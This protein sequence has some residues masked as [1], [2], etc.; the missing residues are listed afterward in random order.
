MFEGDGHVASSRTSMSSALVLVVCRQ[1]MHV[2]DPALQF[3]MDGD[4]AGILAAED[5]EAMVLLVTGVLFLARVREFG[6]TISRD[7]LYVERVTKG[8]LGSFLPWWSGK[9]GALRT[10]LI[11]KT[12]LDDPDITLGRAGIL[13]ARVVAT[14]EACD[15]VLGTDGQSAVEYLLK[16]GSQFAR[17]TVP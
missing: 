10:A 6:Q 12:L 17:L 14:A 8:A 16:W 15:D 1:L 9:G 3:M 5:V 4:R 7:A 2:F 11:T 13:Q